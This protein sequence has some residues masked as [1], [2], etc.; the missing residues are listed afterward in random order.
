M[1]DKITMNIRPKIR[2]WLPGAAMDETDLREEIRMLAKRGFGGIE[3]V[4]LQNLPKEILL[5]DDGWGGANWNRMLDIINDEVKKQ[6]MSLDLAVGPGWPIASPVIKSADD[7][8]VLHELTYGCLNLTGGTHYAGPLPKRRV[9]REAGMPERIAVMAY[10]VDTSDP[11]KN[12]KEGTKV[13][14]AFGEREFR[15][16]LIVDSY[17]NLDD[18]IQRYPGTGGEVK[19]QI[20]WDVPGT[21][22][23]RW[24]LFVFWQQPAVQKING[25]STYVVDHLSAEGT[26]AVADYWEPLLSLEKYDAM[27]SLF[28]D[29]LEYAVA[30]DWTPGLLETF[31]K[32]R[33]Y[34]LLPWLPFI[35][36][37]DTFPAGDAPGFPSSPENI[38][39]QVNNDYM[40]IL[41]ELYCEE[42]LDKLEKLSEKYGKTVRYQVAY[43]KP[44][45][46]ERCGLYV[47]I[48][49]NE[50]L[51]RSQIDGQRL[52]AAAVHFGRK[53]RY[54]FEC[55]AEFG[56]SYGQSYEDLFWWVKR[57]LM[58]GMDA[59]VLHG[60]SYSGRC[61]GTDSENILAKSVMWPG[62]EGFGRFISNNWNRTPD[63]RHARGCIDTIARM[64]SIFR[65]HARID[66][67][68][69]RQAYENSGLG[70]EHYLYDDGG[71]LMNMGY[72]YEYVSD[73][74][75][76]LPQ[77]EVK[78][79]ELDPEGAGY[80]A[81][82]VPHQKRMSEHAMRRILTLAEQKLPIILVGDAPEESC[83]YMEWRTE[84]DRKRWRICRDRLWNGTMANIVRV[85]EVTDV[86]DIL[87]SCNVYPRILLENGG[88]LIT[89][90]RSEE[91]GNR[92][93]YAVYGYNR[94]HTGEGFVGPGNADP[95]DVKPVYQRPGKVSGRVV[96]IAL[97]GRGKVSRFDPWSGSHRKEHF[98]Y[99]GA[100]RMR[101]K[102]YVEEDEMII[103]CVDCNIVS[104][105][106]NTDQIEAP[107]FRKAGKIKFRE[108]SFYEFGPDTPDEISFL[109]SRF[110]DTP[111]WCSTSDSEIELI[112]W[113]EMDPALENASGEG[114]YRGIIEIEKEPR[115]E[116]RLI[117]SLG[118]V[119]DTFT[120]K[121]NGVEAPFPDQVMKRVDITG[122]GQ[123]GEN[124]IE[125]RV[126]SELHN[127]L[128]GELWRNGSDAE[129]KRTVCSLR[130]YGIC[131]SD[132]KPM[133]VYI[134]N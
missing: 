85:A 74:L 42:H 86:P 50:A 38:R 37:C 1:H 115:G 71:R 131:P 76:W 52:M 128:M 13:K 101:G 118:D 47:G 81:L 108:F 41:T 28:C 53:S 26:K 30:A 75:L 126:V 66:L 16:P 69:F 130:R 18:C 24:M 6:G 7:P 103:L 124:Q 73:F 90:V 34:D 20:V 3:V 44:F 100:G 111:S 29:S 22:N 14:T 129:R 120:V 70:A 61:V 82:I 84:G 35:G 56:Q 17:I 88:D 95:K 31:R 4:V 116:E 123:K 105:E 48:P 54:S 121:I 32:R 49:E 55:A 60:A 8:G 93:W 87:I 36:M 59:Q 125:V 99:D 51:G 72:S 2:F 77:A 40:E 98:V 27:E 11:E 12:K 45:E 79:G 64:N 83:Y 58:A 39:T 57:S 80:H 97:S 122:L 96:E 94:I 119:Y 67:C 106:I 10:R 15:L 114:I 62:Y 78:G 117:V 89:A 109:R 43:N 9:I 68:I 110:A 91:A 63:L 19:E 133:E 23:E 107:I 65:K 134:V 21:S 102:I 112:P 127:Q 5:S 92:I 132:E 33:H 25:G 46:E 113:H 104:E